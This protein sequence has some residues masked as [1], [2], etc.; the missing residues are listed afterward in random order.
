MND[1][2]QCKTP[3]N[4]VLYFFLQNKSS[5]LL[6]H[7][8]SLTTIFGVVVIIFLAVSNGYRSTVGE[9][10]V[11]DTFRG[12]CENV[13]SGKLYFIAY[14]KCDDDYHK[15]TFINCVDKL[16]VHVPYL[17]QGITG[18]FAHV[19]GERGEKGRVRGGEGRGE[20]RGGEGREERGERGKGGVGS[21]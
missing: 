6:Q 8:A 2:F 14:Y 7:F 3:P 5:S 21:W 18:D 15:G 10:F 20:E 9:N 16:L 11:V 13:C 17:S 12:F 1:P 4:R 19:R